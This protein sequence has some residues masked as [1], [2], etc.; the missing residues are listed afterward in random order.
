MDH[1]PESVSSLPQ[2]FNATSML[3]R[4]ISR[5]YFNY[6]IPVRSLMYAA[7][8]RY[9]VHIFRGKKFP[10][11]KKSQND[12]T[13]QNAHHVINGHRQLIRVNVRHQK[14]LKLLKVQLNRLQVVEERIDGNCSEDTRQAL[15]DAQHYTTTKSNVT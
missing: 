1:I 14:A 5:K 12:T 8:L 11:Y 9:E 15:H 2:L 4:I 3:Y 10:K 6:P 13:S 7:I